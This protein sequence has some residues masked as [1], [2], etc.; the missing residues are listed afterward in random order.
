MKPR[1]LLL[2]A[3]IAAIALTSVSAPIAAS[4]RAT[5]TIQ[6]TF[7]DDAENIIRCPERYECTVRLA[8]GEVINKGDASDIPGWSPSVAYS[9]DVAQKTA[10]DAPSTSVQSSPT[11]RPYLVLRPNRAGLRSNIFVTTNQRAYSF[12]LLSERGVVPLHYVLRY[13][14]PKPLTATP[15]ATPTPTPVTDLSDI[16]C[17]DSNYTVDDSP[18]HKT[19]GPVPPSRF[20]PTKTCNDG[21]HTYIQLQQFT[22]LP[23]DLPVL[24]SIDR[25][26]P[27]GV[28][29]NYVYDA[30]HFRYIVD[31]VPDAMQLLYGSPKDRILVRIHHTIGELR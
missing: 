21:A 11:L 12:L 4:A 6:L 14:Q 29:T 27:G 9:G 25:Q 17:K 31:G 7:I 19:R 1:L 20:V 3:A 30:A 26:H 10:P 18:D 28:I 8:P 22:E 24:S 15:I 2:R 23:N 16:P 13:P 5:T